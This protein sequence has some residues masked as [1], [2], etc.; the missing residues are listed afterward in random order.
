M[1]AMKRVLL[2]GA[3]GFVGRQVLQPLLDRG[4]EVH[5]ASRQAP[6]SVPKPVV[7]HTA[8]LLDCA[9]HRPLLERIR[10][11]HLLHAAWYVEHGKYWNA[12]ENAH[13]LKATLALVEAFCQ[14]GGERVV[15]VGSCAEYDWRYGV[16]IEDA[17][18]E[19]P[20]SLYGSAKLAAGRHAAALAE[21]QAIGFAWARI[22]FPYGP[23]EAESRLIPHVIT[24]LLRG[25]Q[26][27]CTHGR[28]FRDFLHVADVGDVLAAVLDSSL[29]GS[30]NVGSGVPT[31]IADVVT[32]IGAMLERPDLLV[33]GAV[34]EPENSPPMILASIDRLVQAVHWAPKHSLD[35]GLRLTIDWW[36]EAL[37]SRTIDRT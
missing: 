24:R 1:G 22:F 27:R 3:S 5:V 7:V 19:T 35:Q 21:A 14:S 15:G 25:Q 12:V 31:S 26:A 36:R 11:T 28:Q 37:A 33:L 16:L 9:T 23:G 18:P 6:H 4:Y 8:D 34:T 29:C 10:P 2:S 32:R 17:T 13:W 30:V 20:A